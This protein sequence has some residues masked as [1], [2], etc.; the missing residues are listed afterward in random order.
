VPAQ[1]EAPHAAR[2]GRNFS[3][4]IFSDPQ[5]RSNIAGGAAAAAAA[6]APEDG[7]STRPLPRGRA[8]SVEPGFSSSRKR[9]LPAPEEARGV[10]TDQWAAARP[11][12]REPLPARLHGL[13]QPRPLPLRIRGCRPA[14]ARRPSLASSG[15]AHWKAAQHSGSVE[16]R[17]ARSEK[18]HYRTVQ[19]RSD[20]VWVGPGANR[21]VIVS[22]DSDD[23]QLWAGAEPRVI[24]SIGNGITTLR[25]FPHMERTSRTPDPTL[26][27]FVHAG[28]LASKAGVSTSVPASRTTARD[29]SLEDFPPLLP[30]PRHRGAPHPGGTSAQSPSKVPP[31]FVLD[32][33]RF[34]PSARASPSTAVHPG[35]SSAQPT[36]KVPPSVRLGSAS[37]Q[38]SAKATPSTAVRPG[39]SSAQPTRPRCQLLK[40]PSLRRFILELRLFCHRPRRGHLIGHRPR[41]PLLQRFV[42]S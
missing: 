13:P 8:R 2:P 32:L 38:P 27:S 33:H 25:R 15:G 18:K 40:H 34:Q 26:W 21:R 42:R 22:I 12:A 10:I 17:G 39:A 5:Y 7:Y 6:P 9:L 11:G 30:H 24:V 41:H 28:G 14:A 3:S 35:A 29:P 36:A 16:R 31:R 19:I 23:F 1:R 20:A 37:V 4:S